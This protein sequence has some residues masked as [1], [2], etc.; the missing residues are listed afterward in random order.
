[1]SMRWD[2]FLTADFDIRQVLQF[3]GHI[4]GKRVG[5]GVDGAYDRAQWH[6]SL[7]NLGETI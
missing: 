6:V 2:E 3:V 4:A 1:M 5:G 7:V